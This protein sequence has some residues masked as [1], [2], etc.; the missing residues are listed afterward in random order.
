MKIFV[1]FPPLEGKGTPM[2]GQNR[3]FQWFHNPSF[4][5]PMV[6]ASAATLLKEK[7]HEVFWD[8]GIARKWKKDQWWD[9]LRFESS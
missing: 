3:Q 9:N 4:I 6:P 5:Y 7:G 2:L 1:S 8:D